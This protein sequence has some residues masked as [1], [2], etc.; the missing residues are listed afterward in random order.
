MAVQGDAVA[1]RDDAV[2]VQGNA[3]AVQGNAVAAS[4]VMVPVDACDSLPSW[5][6]AYRTRRSMRVP[7]KTEP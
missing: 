1:V 7:E 4:A 2:A 6:L 3:V 5:N